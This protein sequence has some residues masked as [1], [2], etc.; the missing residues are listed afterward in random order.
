MQGKMLIMYK[1]T[2]LHASLNGACSDIHYPQDEC[3]QHGECNVA[4]ENHNGRLLNANL[5]LT[6]KN[7]IQ[8]LPSVENMDVQPL[9]SNVKRNKETRHIKVNSR[10]YFLDSV[11]NY[12][13]NTD[14]YKIIFSYEIFRSFDYNE[15]NLFINYLL[16]ILYDTQIKYFQTINGTIKESEVVINFYDL[17]FYN[18]DKEVLNFNHK[19]S[20]YNPFKKNFNYFL[21]FKK[22]VRKKYF[23]YKF[24]SN[25]QTR[26]YKHYA[27]I[28][29]K[30]KEYSKKSVENLIARTIENQLALKEYEF[31]LKF[32]PELN[33]L[34]QILRQV[35]Y[36]K[37]RSLSVILNI[38]ILILSKFK[39][40]KT[41]F[42][43]G[44][45]V[46]LNNFKS[47]SDP[48]SLIRLILI[49]RILLEE[50]FTEFVVDYRLSSLFDYINYFLLLENI[51]PNLSLDLSQ[52]DHYFC[53]NCKYI[54][55]LSNDSSKNEIYLCINEYF[56]N[57]KFKDKYESIM[58]PLLYNDRNYSIH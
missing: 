49:T 21:E 54:Q 20:R 7:F 37:Y 31:F 3:G 57:T 38:F 40:F 9:Y 16:N 41:T 24:K 56:I 44:N 43:K 45:D 58:F 50:I 10:N 46:T 12:I 47:I 51:H 25:Q 2:I 52:I 30:N 53:T 29:N 32:I 4:I 6:Q 27:Q 35:S 5:H 13:V 55:I 36:I 34:P 19:F 11:G 48:N 26:I 23:I 39:A 33:L 14:E 17:L 42:I 1:I 28:C 22:K 8:S 18:F 15:S